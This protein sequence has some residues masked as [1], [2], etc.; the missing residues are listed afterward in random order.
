MKM[1][2]LKRFIKLKKL[3][4]TWKQ[5]LKD[6]YKLPHVTGE[7]KTS[8]TI[9]DAKKMQIHNLD[10]VKGEVKKFTD[11]GNGVYEISVVYKTK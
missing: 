4:S 1:V 11:L 8:F 7:I 6:K 9:E 5:R 3:L 2:N 10:G